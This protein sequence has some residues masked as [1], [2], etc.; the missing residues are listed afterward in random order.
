MPWA[1]SKHCEILQF[2]DIKFRK[3]LYLIKTHIQINKLLC[4]MDMS[5]HCTLKN[6][7]YCKHYNI[8]RE[9]QKNYFSAFC[10][11]PSCHSYYLQYLARLAYLG[12]KYEFEN[13]PPV[14]CY[15]IIIPKNGW[16]FFVSICTFSKCDSTILSHGHCYFYLFRWRFRTIPRSRSPRFRSP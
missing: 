16:L 8:L 1:I 14:Y 12:R 5:R 9:S 3:Q 11:S 10:K 2:G 13:N 15:H 4:F 7:C 6:I